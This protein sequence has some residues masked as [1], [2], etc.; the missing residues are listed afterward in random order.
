M[1][2]RIPFDGSKQ[3]ELAVLVFALAGLALVA[4]RCA[5]AAGPSFFLG[6]IATSAALG[7]TLYFTCSRYDQPLR[8]RIVLFLIGASLFGAAAFR[9][10]THA[11]F[12]IEGLF[13][14]LLSGVFAA[15]VLHYL[16]AKIAG[17]LIFG[18]VWCGWACWTAALLDQLPYK[19]SRGRLP[20]WWGWLRYVHFGLSLAL[21]AALWY[22]FSYRPG[23]G[24]ATALTWFLAGNLAY[25][26]VGVTL[27]IALKDN[28][29]FCKY[30]CPV[31]VPLK[32]G[33]R[34]S[35]LKVTGDSA[36]CC[37]RQVCE[38]ICPMDIQIAEYIKRGERVLSTECILC[39]AC[40]D[41]CPEQALALSFSLDRGGKEFLRGRD[42]AAR[43]LE[44]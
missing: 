40:I 17:P 9:D 10:S 37:E 41:V 35:L 15:A 36:K 25:Y 20:G 19:R 2:A 5:G 30:V 1:K 23:A 43:K 31:S 39:Q 42:Q 11:L 24:G 12:Q 32:L 13:F 26:L 3:A 14:D 38:K 44:P 4:W 33:A 6:Y 22:G 28:R 27:A 21:V 8:R 16:L 34:F 29:A 18:R 7:L